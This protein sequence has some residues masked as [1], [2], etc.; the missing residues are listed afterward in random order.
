MAIDP[1]AKL[2]AA[3]AKYTQDRTSLSKLLPTLRQAAAGP[4]LSKARA[5]SARSRAVVAA[6]FDP[7]KIELLFQQASGFLGSAYASE[8]AYRQLR[9]AQINLGLDLNEL[10]ELQDINDDEVANN[11]FEVPLWAAQAAVLS[12]QAIVDSQGKLATWVQGQTDAQT[13]NAVWTTE[14]NEKPTGTG[15][16]SSLS[17]HTPKLY[18][19]SWKLDP[20]EQSAILGSVPATAG[21]AIGGVLTSRAAKY[22]FSY[23]IQQINAQAVPPTSRLPPMTARQNYMQLDTGFRE[24][25]RDVAHEKLV[26]KLNAIAE[27]D[28]SMNYN[29]RATRLFSQIETAISEAVVRLTVAKAGLKLVFGEDTADLPTPTTSPTEPL[30][31][32]YLFALGQWCQVFADTLQQLKRADQDFVY[33]TSL[34]S[35]IGADKFFQELSGRSWTFQLPKDNFAKLKLLRLKGVAVWTSYGVRVDT[36]IPAGFNVVAPASS[37]ALYGGGRA[38]TITQTLNHCWIGRSQE[39]DPSG[40]R[41]PPDIGG[42][43]ILFNASPIGTWTVSALAGADVNNLQDII[44]E[45]FLTVQQDV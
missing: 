6:D 3:R 8:A 23:A 13:M 15:W 39:W 2:A 45:I 40:N 21:Y 5:L 28:G 26:A 38:G 14:N 33:R 1:G 31:S 44:L 19:G 29:E 22:S 42:A 16:E 12:D 17:D 43:G 20:T 41:I 11:V 27:P 24:R 37:T 32:D 36:I 7:Q 4:D 25:R 10:E 9:V 30:S 35:L 18:P 34:R